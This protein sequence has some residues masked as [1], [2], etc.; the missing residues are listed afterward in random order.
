MLGCVIGTEKGFVHPKA[1]SNRQKC[2]C[3]VPLKSMGMHLWLVV[4]WMSFVHASQFCTVCEAFPVHVF[5]RRSQVAV[6]EQ[7]LSSPSMH[8]T[9]V[10]ASHAVVPA[11]CAHSDDAVHGLHVPPSQCAAVALPQSESRRHATH[12]ILSSSQKGVG[13]WHP[14]QGRPVLELLAVL[15]ELEIVVDSVVE[16]FVDAVVPVPPDPVVQFAMSQSWSLQPTTGIER[17]TIAK[18]ASRCARIRRLLEC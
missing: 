8:S 1:T 16:L 7:A 12:I 11:R 2:P 18:A 4:H 17:T 10:P 15:V 3:G 14:P 5:A 9:H 6:L 13:A